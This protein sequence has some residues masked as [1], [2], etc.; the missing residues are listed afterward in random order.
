MTSLFSNVSQQLSLLFGEPRGTEG[1]IPHDA[2]PQQ[3]DRVEECGPH[4]CPDLR[5]PVWGWRCE[6]SP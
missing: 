3:A 4:V 1:I 5:I 6:R 2:D